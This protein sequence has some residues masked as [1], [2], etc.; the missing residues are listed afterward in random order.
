MAKKS[1]GR[2]TAQTLSKAA[3]RAER[4]LLRPNEQEART[5]EVMPGAVETRPELFQPRM[6]THGGRV[7]DARHV[8]KLAKRIGNTGAELEPVVVVK[9]SGRWV[10]VDG[11]HRLEAYDWLNWEGPI[12]A[13]W[14]E[15][16]VREAVD[17][18]LRLNEVDKLEMSLQD[19]YEQAWQRT[20]LR[21]GSKAEV[22]KATNVSTTLVAHMRRVVEAYYRMDETGARMRRSLGLLENNTWSAARSAHLGTS[23]AGRDLQ[24][25]A[26]TLAKQLTKR[27]TNMLSKDPEVTALAL[28]LY[29]RDLPQPLDDALQ[30]YITKEGDDD[31]AGE[32]PTVP[33]AAIREMTADQLLE[34][35]EQNQ[36]MSA[37]LARKRME[38]AGEQ[39]RRAILGTPSEV[40]GME[41][42]KEAPE[43]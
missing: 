24:E 7:V 2:Q 43:A 8:K 27:M 31:G 36:D 16:T 41:L 3:L 40:P 4:E 30:Q 15:G 34:R 19:N 12:K 26:A 10:C 38:L 20:V 5:I 29:D 22:V 18:S 35:L 21:W 42:T 28:K 9:L 1:S 11:H 6:L 33:G 23:S 14:F 39:D 17:E 37:Y 32:L 13:I 25:R